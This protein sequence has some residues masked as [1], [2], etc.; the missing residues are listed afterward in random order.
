MSTYSIGVDG[1]RYMRHIDIG[2]QFGRWTVYDVSREG[3]KKNLKYHVRC[4]CGTT[5]RIAPRELNGGYTKSCGCLRR[6]LKIAEGNARLF[7]GV[8]T[9][10]SR[11]TI[12]EELAPRNERRRWLAKCDCGTIKE[13][14]NEQLRNGTSRSCGC[15]ARD[16]RIARQTIHGA[17][18]TPEYSSWKGARARCEDPEH[19]NFPYYG[20]RG[21]RF[22]PEWNNFNVFLA[23][24]GPR[25]TKS[26]TLDRIDVDGDY[27][28]GNCRWATPKEQ[29]ANKR[30]RQRI[31][32]YTDSELIAELS[33]RGLSVTVEGELH[34]LSMAA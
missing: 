23:D 32:Q 14:R 11:W 8:G 29:A 19:H 20:G 22:S 12:L 31:E 24:V 18:R 7:I 16:E 17:S 4:E 30:K 27:T 28:R 6:E 1:R 13:V 15:L 26:H 5:R 25:P 9:K 34:A 3:P 10:I 2:D 21:I 33:R